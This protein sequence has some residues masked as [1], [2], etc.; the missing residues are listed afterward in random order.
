M[1]P[2]V[3]EAEDLLTVAEIAVIADVDKSDVNRAIDDK[4]LPTVLYEVQDHHRRL[5]T[6]AAPLV[7]FNSGTFGWLTPAAR[8]EA[9]HAFVRRHETELVTVKWLEHATPSDRDLVSLGPVKLDLWEHF[10]AARERAKLLKAARERI[11]RDPGI[12]G[13]EPVV[14]G[15]RVPAYAV[16]SAVKAEYP[17]EEVLADYPSLT[18]EDVKLADIWA[19]ANPPQGRP[20]TRLRPPP[21]PDIVSKIVPRRPRNEAAR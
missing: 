2:P 13:G 21:G 14:A 18:P 6:S 1:P 7:A 19:R 11:V 17:V 9:V 4:V 12:L 15:T 3:A 16:R 20:R 5:N 10:D 8:K